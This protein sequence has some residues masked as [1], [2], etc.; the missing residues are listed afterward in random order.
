VLI[1]NKTFLNQLP[2]D[3]TKPPFLLKAKY[4]SRAKRFFKALADKKTF[5]DISLCKT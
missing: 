2:F 4:K 1:N 3:K 5:M